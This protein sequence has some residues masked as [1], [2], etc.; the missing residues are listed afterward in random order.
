MKFPKGGGRV[1]VVYAEGE[2]V[3]GW[4]SPKDVGGDR[5][6]HDLRLLRGDE[7][8]KAIVLRVNSPGGSSFASDIVA[9][10]IGL[11]RAKGLPVVVSMGD[12]AASGGYYIAANG[13]VIMADP[14]TL[15]GSIGVFGLHFNYE[16]LA[17]TI[18][19]G[20]DGV[21]TAR[22]AD[23][24]NVHRAASSEELAIL[25]VVVDKVYEDFLNIVSEGRKVS[26]DDVHEIAQGRV[27]TGSVAKEIKLIDRFGG[28]RDAIKLAAQ[29]AKLNSAEIVQVPSLH[30]GWDDLLQK[31]LSDDHNASPL[32]AKRS[33]KDVALLFLQS[34]LET[35]RA[36]RALNDPKSI[37]LSCPAK[38]I[39]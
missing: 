5:L 31:L 30:S 13:S 29:M 12:V 25:Q 26:R 37:Y 33:G 39:R 18:N 36:L 21:K 20:T 34:H 27:W 19:L 15:T 9:R 6:A 16:E 35:L 38:P 3:D 17:K 32:F 2:I 28:L 23:L 10:E 22:Y 11:L 4:G 14:S 7:R 8:V 24:L 1:A